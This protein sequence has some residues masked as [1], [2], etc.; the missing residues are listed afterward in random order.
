MPTCASRS[1]L[2]RKA[3]RK[4]QRKRQR[5]RKR[6]K[7]RRRRTLPKVAAWRGATPT[8]HTLSLTL[9]TLLTPLPSPLHNIHAHPSIYGELVVAGILKPI[10]TT[11]LSD[12]QG[13]FKN[14]DPAAAGRAGDEEKPLTD[15]SLAAV[16][17]LLME[18]VVLPL[19][20]AHALLFGVEL[21]VPTGLA[22]LLRK[23]RSKCPLPPNAVAVW[24]AAG[25]QKHVD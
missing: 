12:F 17:Q 18:Q 8:P 23:C 4:R 3:K 16:R 21:I 1:R 7:E 15:P 20:F 24:P 9:L 10:P 2:G 25:R 14:A 13:S 5:K 22:P 19:P 11:R 6:K